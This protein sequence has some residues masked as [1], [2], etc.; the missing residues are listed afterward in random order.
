MSDIISDILLTKYPHVINK[1]IEY[2]ENLLI[3]QNDEKFTIK[4]CNH[5]FMKNLNIEEKPCMTPIKDYFCSVDGKPFDFNILADSTI[6]FINLLKVRSTNTLIK[7]YFFKDRGDTI[8][9]GEKF[10]IEETDVVKN[11]SILTSEI[12]KISHELKKKNHALLEADSI[13]QKDL[14]MAVNVQSAFLEQTPPVSKNF[15]IAFTFRP[16]NGISGDFYDFYI[17]EGILEGVGIFDVSGH[18]IASGLITLIA[19]S[20]IFSIFRKNSSCHLNTIMQKINRKLIDNIGSIDSYITGI[21]LK[22]NGNI[23][24][25]ANSGHPDLLHKSAAT[26]KIKKI[27]NDDGT[28]ITGPFLGVEIMESDFESV[29]VVLEKGDSIIL[30]TDSL[31]ETTGNDLKTY[32]ERI[33]EVLSNAPDETAQSLLDYLLNDFHSSIENENSIRDDLTVIVL[34]KY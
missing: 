10:S 6:P 11:L 29:N 20:I 24:E 28:S 25:Y 18:G 22:I 2:S 34:K 3:V 19:K 17:R 30:F 21:L 26:G 31:L 14:A 15:D 33:L 13:Y 5:G 8:L 16:M 32:D 23:L 4:D 12:S 7:S 27:V 1:Y 9:I